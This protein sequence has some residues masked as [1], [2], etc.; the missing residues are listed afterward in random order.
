MREILESVELI[1]ICQQNLYLTYA[2]IYILVDLSA[3][4]LESLNDGVVL[5]NSLSSF[6]TYILVI[7]Q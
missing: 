2:R 6:L 5:T 7:D 4:T 3:N 1:W